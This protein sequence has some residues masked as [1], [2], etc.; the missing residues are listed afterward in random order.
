MGPLAGIGDTITQGTIIPILLSIGIG[1][2]MQG[3]VFGP[4][5]FVLSLLVVLVGITYTCW[6]QGYK[7]GRTA[8]ESILSG[9]LVNDIISAAGVLGCIVIGA[10]TGQFVSVS[11]PLTV[12]IGETVINIQE[13]LLD[14]IMPKLLP[15]VLVFI[16]FS[17]LRKGK[18]P[19]AIMVGIA[20]VGIIGSLLGIF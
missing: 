16:V 1:F 12:S 19:T 13:G 9:G 6:M 18:N 14:K 4:V 2:G 20:V 8:V 3:N 17:L 5:F 11:T 7:V 15:L 10:L